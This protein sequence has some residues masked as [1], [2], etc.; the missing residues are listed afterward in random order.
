MSPLV[1]GPK[2]HVP[3][4]TRALRA[5]VASTVGT[6]IEWYD[7]FLYGVAAAIV[8]P[9]V[10]F[11]TSD[12]AS[13]TLASFGTYFV[14]FVA[15]P[16]GAAIF[17]HFGDRLGRKA[18]LVATLLLMGVATV[19]IGLVPT[20]IGVWGAVL[21]TLCRILQGIGVGGEWAGSVLVAAE[22]G[23]AHR[24]GLFASWPQFGAPAGLL[25][26]NG[27]MLAASRWTGDAF[28]EW[29]WRLPFLASVVLVGIGLWIRRGV[30]ETPAFTRLTAERRVER[31]PVAVALSKHW[32][33]IALTGL[34]RTGQQTPF[35]V[36]TAFVL[37][38]ATQH[39][40]LARSDVLVYVLLGAT[41]SLVTIPLSGHLADRYGALRV[42]V[43][44]AV[45]MVVFPFVYFLALDTAAHGWV[46]L[47]I[48]VAAPIHD[49]QY[50]P[51]AAVIADAFPP[52]VRYSGASLGYQLASLTAGGPAP[53]VALWLL[54]STGASWSIA[55]YLSFTAIV[56][57]LAA[58]GLARHGDAAARQA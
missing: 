21:L 6:A 13:A 44:G 57:L 8:F 32:K 55:A 53:I 45:L 30:E 52:E 49:L 56:T 46:L 37:S 36:V 24:R 19:A 22:W 29:G 41:V 18:S 4:D 26:A 50:A 42:V 11:P 23:P 38:Y 20:G 33:A 28:L 15:R 27:A 25:L 17:G 51:Q 3:P 9:K 43:A 34:L 47:A 48:L 7:F 35:Y 5:V 1:R 58:A 14:G 2:T 40:G 10:F 54:E 16:V 39:L 31:A 12:P